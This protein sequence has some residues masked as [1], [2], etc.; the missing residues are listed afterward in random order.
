[1]S[2]VSGRPVEIE[3]GG[4]AHHQHHHVRLDHVTERPERGQRVLLAG[5]VDHHHARGRHLL[6]GGDRGPHA[7]AAELQ[8]RG[9]QIAQAV[10]QRRLGDGIAHE[11][12]GRQPVGPA[13]LDR[14][15]SERA[16]HHE[17][18]G[19]LPP[20]VPLPFDGATV[21]DWL[22]VAGSGFTWPCHQRPTA[23]LAIGE[24]TPSVPRPRTRSAGLA[25]WTARLRSI[26]PLGCHMPARA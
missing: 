25:T 4:I 2:R 16:V 13:Q 9:Q 18:P 19:W 22:V 24:S 6:Q 26:M 8:R 12:H 10:A 15:R 21:V 17:P 14:C 23:A 7:A 11:R 5:D 1:V 20:P 3:I